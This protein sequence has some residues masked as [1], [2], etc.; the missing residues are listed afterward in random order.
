MKVHYMSQ[1]D[2]WATPQEFYNRL[3]SIYHFDLDAA[4][5]STNKK[6][7]KWYGLDHPDA[8]RRDGLTVDWDGDV[9]WLN[10][11]YGRVIGHWLKKA[12]EESANRTVVLLLPA[13]TD[14]HWFHNYCTP[15]RITFLRGRLKFGDA[16]HAAPFP[17]MI[18]EMI[19]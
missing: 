3:N 5:S 16:I 19:K 18:V 2:N 12:H 17:S 1:S 6:C 11:P 4:A 10:P 13:R 9:V 7:D 14:T 8:D 15:H